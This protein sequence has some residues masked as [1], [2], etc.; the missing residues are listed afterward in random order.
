M[1]QPRLPETPQCTKL[2]QAFAQISAVREFLEK[3]LNL[4]PT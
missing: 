2:S 3:L 1:E 4:F